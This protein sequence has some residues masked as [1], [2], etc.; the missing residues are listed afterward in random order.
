MT[1]DKFGR[2]LQGHY[3]PG[4]ERYG[5]HC[6]EFAGGVREEVDELKKNVLLVRK[7][8]DGERVWN[9]IDRRI[10]NLKSPSSRKDAVT[11]QY[12]DNTLNNHFRLVTG[13]RISANNRTVSDVADPTRP[14]DVVTLSYLE[15]KLGSVIIVDREDEEGGRQKR[16]GEGRSERGGDGGGG[17]EEKSGGGTSPDG[18]PKI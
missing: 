17:V 3:Y 10:V 15:K 14:Q 6:S 7:D 12:V 4:G 9:G 11:K 2:P 1:V 16:E 13:N 18:A 8:S 5:Q